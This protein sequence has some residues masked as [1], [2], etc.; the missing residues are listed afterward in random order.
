MELEAGIYCAAAHSVRPG[1]DYA[2]LI[3]G[4]FT[5]WE[6]LVSGQINPPPPKKNWGDERINEESTHHFE[7]S[8]PVRFVLI[9]ALQSIPH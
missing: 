1:R 8:I 7:T 3:M 9:R 6:S 5:E 2:E 4:M